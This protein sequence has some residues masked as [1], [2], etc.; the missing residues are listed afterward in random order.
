MLQ[1]NVTAMFLEIS[2]RLLAREDVVQVAPDDGAFRKLQA[3]NPRTSRR[4]T[5]HL[6]N[7]RR[8]HSH[9]QL[10]S[11]CASEAR[12]ASTTKMQPI[13]STAQ[14]GL[15]PPK[16]NIVRLKITFDLEHGA[17][18]LLCWG[19][20]PLSIAETKNHLNWHLENV[21]IDFLVQPRP[22]RPLNC[23]T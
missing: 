18:F 5:V 14:I 19:R 11:N 22:Y 1:E 4:M 17:L 13:R 6:Q 2:K 12:A 16:C 21:E 23:N 15:K 10:R 7:V 3:S 9:R 20:C 8:P